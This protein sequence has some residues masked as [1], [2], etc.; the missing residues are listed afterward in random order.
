MT[1]AARRRS[2]PREPL[3]TGTG[4]PGV[5]VTAAD[6]VARVVQRRGLAAPGDQLVGLARHGGH[7]HG[8]VVAGIDLAFDVARHVTDAVHV[9]DGGAAE[10]HD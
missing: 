9:G 4:A 2:A 8:D 10:F 7:D 6:L 5:Y 3:G 1:L